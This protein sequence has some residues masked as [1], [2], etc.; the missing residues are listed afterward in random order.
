ML[1]ASNYRKSMFTKELTVLVKPHSK[2]GRRVVVYNK[3]KTAMKMAGSY[4]VGA[5]PTTKY[6][7]ETKI[8]KGGCKTFVFW[9]N[10]LN[11]CES[12]Y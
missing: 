2:H 6:Y 5:N 11:K 12:A 10:S 1:V 8:P 7:K 9:N 4:N 3:G